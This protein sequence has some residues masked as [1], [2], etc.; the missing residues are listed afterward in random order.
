MSN[1]N[2]TAKKEKKPKKSLRDIAK[3]VEKAAADVAEKS[4]EFIKETL[5]RNDDG[6]I[7]I[8]DLGIEKQDIIDAKEKA[9]RFADK[10]R[11][12]IKEKVKKMDENR[13]EAKLE[14]DRK[15][16]RP[17]FVED[18][19]ANNEI[20]NL[21]TTPNTDA[22]YSMIRIVERDKK[23]EENIACRG[24]IG[25]LTVTKE[26]DVLNIYVDVAKSLGIRFL[27]TIENEVYYT[28][29]FKENVYVNLEEY[30]NYLKKARISE[31]E[32]VASDLGAKTV[33]IVFKEYSSTVSARKMQA[34]TKMTGKMKNSADTSV[35]IESNSSDMSNMEIAADIS[36]S[37]HDNP[38]IP[39]LVYFKGESDILQL[40]KMRT[41]PE[42]K[43][44]IVSKT[45]ALRYNKSSGISQ[46]MA[47]QIDAALTG[48]S[49]K[50]SATF[51]NEVKRETRTV[52][53]YHIEF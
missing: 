46:K 34:K 35:D 21:A 25:Y 23:R 11:E 8:E 9:Q 40:I 16:L 17:V 50:Q 28:D 3:N 2:E 18:F 30:F 41:D 36:F 5:D 32:M 19:L 1:S 26:L 27:P 20:N 7:S 45:Y 38:R 31:L 12:G 42:K 39:K 43:N 44:R 24:A 33:K 22:R 47:N 52:L 29:P 4:Q 51:S 10:T 49:L 14:R 13:S 6:K 15:T 53:E 37:G 48:M